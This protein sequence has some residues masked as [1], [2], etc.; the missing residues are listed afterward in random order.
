VVIVV[1]VETAE[2]AE[3]EVAMVIVVGALLERVSQ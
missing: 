2:T 3:I 1:I